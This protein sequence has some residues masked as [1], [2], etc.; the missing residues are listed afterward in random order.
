MSPIEDCAG[1]RLAVH[2]VAGAHV[3]VRSVRRD[4]SLRLGGDGREHAVLVEALTVGASSIGGVLE[5]RAT[6]L[7]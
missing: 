4:E 5:T 2:I 7:E 3:R 6:N 1:R